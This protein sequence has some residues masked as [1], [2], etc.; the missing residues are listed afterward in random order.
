MCMNTS[1]YVL[2]TFK[3]LRIIR[4]DMFFNQLCIMVSCKVTIRKFKMLYFKM[5][6]VTELEKRSLLISTGSSSSTLIYIKILRTS[7][8]S[9]CNLTM[10]LWKP[11]RQPFLFCSNYNVKNVLFPGQVKIATMKTLLRFFD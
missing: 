4:G 3:L 11:S 2:E 8:F 1:R 6:D 9:F 5:K 10:S 7:R